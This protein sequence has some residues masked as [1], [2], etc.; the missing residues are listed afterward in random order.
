MFKLYWQDH[1]NE[2]K[3]VWRGDWPGDVFEIISNEEFAE[4]QKLENGLLK[5]FTFHLIEAE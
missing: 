1:D 3:Q 5:R 4:L 2:T